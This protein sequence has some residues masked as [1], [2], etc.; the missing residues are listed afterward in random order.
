M[1]GLSNVT[2]R[3][4]ALRRKVF[5]QPLRRR[6]VAAF[7]AAAVL[8]VAL[9]GGMRVVYAD[10]LPTQE[11]ANETVAETVA[12]ETVAVEEKPVKP[13]KGEMRVRVV[14]PSGKPLPGAKV[15][16]VLDE[17]P[18]TRQQQSERTCDGD[19]TTVVALPEQGRETLLIWVEA[20]NRVPLRARWRNYADHK[21]P[22]PSE[23]EFTMENGVPIGGVVHDEQGKPI[24]GARV[25]VCGPA[26]GMGV[27]AEFARRTGASSSYGYSGKSRVVMGMRTEQTDAQG[28]WRCSVLREDLKR[29]VISVQHEDHLEDVVH[30]GDDRFAKLLGPLEQRNAVLVMKK[31]IVVEGTVTDPQGSPVADARVMAEDPGHADWTY[32]GSYAATYVYPSTRTSASDGVQTERQG[33]YRLPG[34]RGGRLI[35]RVGAPG[36][37]VDI[38]RVDVKAGMGPVDFQLE[39][40][41]T[42]RIRVVDRD[43]KPVAGAS[44]WPSLQQDRRLLSG[45]G[46]PR[47]TDGQG[48]WSWDGAPADEIT[49]SF[50]KRGYMQVVDRTL[51]TG[52]QQDV[53]TM[54]PPLVISGRVVDART[55]API[56]E[57]GVMRGI[58]LGREYGRHW[59]GSAK[60]I[61]RAHGTYREEFSYPGDVRVIRIEAAG[62]RPAISR[63]VRPEEGEVTIDFALQKGQPESGTALLPDGEP[64]SGATVVLCPESVGMHI[65]A[66]RHAIS[67]LRDLKVTTDAE[68]RFTF[69]PQA[70]RFTLL[71]LH[72]RGFAEVSRTEFAAS[73]QITIRPWA[74]VEGTVRI[75]DRP[76][77]RQSVMLRF[78]PSIR[79]AARLIQFNYNA[80]SDAEGKFTFERVIPGTG[81]VT[82]LTGITQRQGLEVELASGGTA[83]IEIGGTGRPVTGRV[84]LPAD[85]DAGLFTSGGTVQLS[86][87]PPALSVPR[88]LRLEDGAVRQRLLA[89]WRE[90]PEGKRDQQRHN[91][92]Y[93]CGIGADGSFRVEDVPPGAYRLEVVVRI[94]PDGP[95]THHRFYEVLKDVTVGEIPG[96]RSD[97]PLDLGTVKAIY[98]ETPIDKT[99]TGTFHFYTGS[100]SD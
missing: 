84:E 93:Y 34:R 58:D 98:K 92:R 33:H 57:F 5:D 95:A 13:A 18:Y 51:K 2:R 46:V 75:G 25:V 7:A 44:V 42:V 1:A 38:R 19:G 94:E 48:R 53:I 17:G 96:R 54:P 28:K 39:K 22:V 50:S 31:G 60:A 4:S 70:E 64:A 37:A 49:C 83:K 43:G 68:G 81:Y 24:E 66:G 10:P 91:V 41:R 40:G 29:L 76:G 30:R 67:P 8:G 88:D 26:D 73:G 6:S 15:K 21:D 55:K 16:V 35:L 86:R 85:A 82:S 27:L 61:G 20:E 100:V 62:Y 78:F 59:E 52:D 80:R 97:Q 47:Q 65:A 3:L 87:R 9:I 12:A 99:R 79:P 63:K 32:S 90:S 36:L 72:Q 74:R 71:V 56:E 23:F 89:Q 45:L 69:P 77:A 14:D 11:A